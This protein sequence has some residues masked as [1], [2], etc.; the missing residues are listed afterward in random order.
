MGTEAIAHAA[1][2]AGSAVACVA[3]GGYLVANM[4]ERNLA[5]CAANVD[6]AVQLAEESTGIAS[7][8]TRGINGLRSSLS[9]TLSPE[10]IEWL[11]QEF[12]DIGGDPEMLHF[13]EGFNTGYLDEENIINVQ[14]NI[15]PAE[16]ETHPRSIMSPRAAL[17]HELGHAN[18]NLQGT[19]L[20]IGVW[21][22]EFH[23]SYWA[24]V[25]APNL[26]DLDRYHLMQ[27]A[28]LRAQ[29]AGHQVAFNAIM[30]KILYG[31]D[32]GQ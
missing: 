18:A 9:N 6:E 26:S 4:A 25:N 29:E 13:N 15:F 5:K 16:Y 32:Y 12:I 8:L 28:L 17:A 30:M 3:G 1:V 23:A 21:E 11:T 7:N 22:D 31:E 20:G 14:G 27:D 24:A 10:E 2:V 19:K